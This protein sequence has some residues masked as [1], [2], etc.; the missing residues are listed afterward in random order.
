MSYS[1]TVTVSGGTATAS[2]SGPAPDGRYTLAGHIDDQ[3]EDISAERL[4][5]AGQLVSRSSGTVY[6]EV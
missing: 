2:V 3:R 5:D 4:T 1:I 6:K